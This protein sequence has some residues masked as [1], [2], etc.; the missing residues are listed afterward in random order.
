MRA[1]LFRERGGIWEGFVEEVESELSLEEWRGKCV[2]STDPGDFSLPISTD[3][4]QTEPA[5]TLQAGA[6]CSLFCHRWA[7]GLPNLSPFQ[8]SGT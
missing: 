4:C 2:Q 3:R 8:E 5:V 6:I 1:Q 7:L